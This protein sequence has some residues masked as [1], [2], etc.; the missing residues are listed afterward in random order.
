MLLDMMLDADAAS[1]GA[2]ACSSFPSPAWD[3][4]EVRSTSRTGLEGSSVA[5]GE[6]EP[7]GVC[8]RV[9]DEGGKRERDAVDQ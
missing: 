3:M 7:C 5:S 8:S 4:V 9:G 1:T 6:L 2:A